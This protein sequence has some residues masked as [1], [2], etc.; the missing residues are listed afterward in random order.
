[1]RIDLMTLDVRTGEHRSIL[2][3]LSSEDAF[4][5]AAVVALLTPK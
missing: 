4:M 1:M 3:G 2:N 5:S